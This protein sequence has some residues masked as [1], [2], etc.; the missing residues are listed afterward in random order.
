[1]FGSSRIEDEDRQED[2]SLFSLSLYLDIVQDRLVLICSS[3]H[4]HT[5]SIHLVFGLTGFRFQVHTYIVFMNRYNQTS[6]HGLIY[7]GFSSIYIYASYIWKN[8]F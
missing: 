1:M 7:I 4:T 2:F 3:S 6:L 5:S 8:I